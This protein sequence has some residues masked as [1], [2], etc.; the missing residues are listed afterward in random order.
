MSVP[1]DSE[2]KQRQE[3]TDKNANN[4]RRPGWTIKQKKRNSKRKRQHVGP[5]GKGR[6]E[7]IALKND[8]FHA[9]YCFGRV[10]LE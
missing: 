7:Q 8:S 6:K 1:V 3:K 2:K 4:K 5:Q 10:H 9:S